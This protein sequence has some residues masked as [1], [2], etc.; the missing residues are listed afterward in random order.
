MGRCDVWLG[1]QGNGDRRVVHIRRLVR[2]ISEC[3]K[4]GKHKGC[5][6]I[7]QISGASWCKPEQGARGGQRR[8]SSREV[9]S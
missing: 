9:R 3:R 8:N 4:G 5:A 2:K 1:K 6:C 7:E